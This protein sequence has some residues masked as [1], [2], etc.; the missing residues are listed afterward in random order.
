MVRSF[1]TVSL[2]VL[3]AGMVVVGVYYGLAALGLAGLGQPRDPN[4]GAG[5]IPLVGF[6]LLVTGLVMAIKDWGRG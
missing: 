3:A 6:V 1:R 2:L 5:F 4:I